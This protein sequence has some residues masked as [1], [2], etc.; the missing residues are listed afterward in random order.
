MNEDIGFYDATNHE[1]IKGIHDVQFI[2][3]DLRIIDIKRNIVDIHGFPLYLED[4][5]R[6]LFNWQNIISIRKKS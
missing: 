4:T 6:K 5:D 1:D 2:N 3:G